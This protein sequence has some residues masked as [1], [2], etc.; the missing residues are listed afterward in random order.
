MN[1]IN[2]LAEVSL[3]V[4]GNKGSPHIRS[5]FRNGLNNCSQG[6]GLNRLGSA[7]V[8][9]GDQIVVDGDGL[10]SVDHGKHSLGGEQVDTGQELSLIE[11]VVMVLVHAIKHVDSSLCDF[12]NG[13][14]LVEGVLGF[15]F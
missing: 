11:V 7:I 13:Q 9:V 5:H 6:E 10:G 12:K 14:T 3:A 15:L 4:L 8:V 2:K 1:R